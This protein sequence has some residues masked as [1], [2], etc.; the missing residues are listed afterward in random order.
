MENDDNHYEMYNM[1]LSFSTL[2]L[3]FTILMIV[4]NGTP[5]LTQNFALGLL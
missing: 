2:V 4:D 5:Q 1:I 3:L